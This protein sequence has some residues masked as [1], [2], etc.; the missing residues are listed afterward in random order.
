[1]NFI[2]DP[3]TGIKK[4]PG[5]VY[6]TIRTPDP[7]THYRSFVMDT[8]GR[9][10]RLRDGTDVIGYYLDSGIFTGWKFNGTRGVDR[11]IFGSQGHI[12]TKG[13]GGRVDFGRDNVRDVFKF[14]NTI[15][16][17][18]ISAIFGR[19]ISPL[20]HLAGVTITNFGRKDR[21]VLQGKSYGLGDVR[22]D[23]SLPGVELNRLRVELQS[24]L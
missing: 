3:I 18:R 21:I 23:G 17:E 7:G 5:G 13:V 14:T 10:K 16:V 12:I 6:R 24:G 9:S 22:S 2:T 11:L 19:P 4:A 1:M 8:T 20:N 15:N